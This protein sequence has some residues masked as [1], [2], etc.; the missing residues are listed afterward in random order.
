MRILYCRIN[1]FLIN[2]QENKA[3]LQIVEMLSTGPEHTFLAAAG[4]IL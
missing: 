1:I 3:Y 4:F 2:L